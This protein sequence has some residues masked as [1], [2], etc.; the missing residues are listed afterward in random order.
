MRQ[1]ST[2]KGSLKLT[3]VMLTDETGDLQAEVLIA[4]TQQANKF[5]LGGRRMWNGL[6]EVFFWRLYL[7]GNFTGS[8]TGN[9]YHF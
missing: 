5:T 6:N 7:L 1:L 8:L 4:I 2:L 3:K 9:V